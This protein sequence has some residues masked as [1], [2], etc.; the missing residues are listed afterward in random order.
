[1]IK[2]WFNS[3]ID[4]IMKASTNHHLWKNK[5]NTIGDKT[6]KKNKAKIEKKNNS[7]IFGIS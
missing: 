4:K 2:N 3:V 7:F 5:F 1:M 6:I